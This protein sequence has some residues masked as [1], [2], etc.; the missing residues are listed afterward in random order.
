MDKLM[1]VSYEV[2][3]LSKEGWTLHARYPGDEQKEALTE[4]KA[5]EAR[6][7]AATKVIRS[8]YS[9]RGNEEVRKEIYS[10]RMTAAEATTRLPAP[11]K[12]EA[13]P[14]PVAVTPRPSK[15]PPDKREEKRESKREE[16]REGRREGKRGAK[17]RHDPAVYSP[18]SVVIHLLV[19]IA[20]AALMAGLITMTAGAIFGERLPFIGEIDLDRRRTLLSGLFM[21]TFLLM[22]VPWIVS[23]ARRVGEIDFGRDDGLPKAKTKP[24]I[25]APRDEPHQVGEGPALPMTTPDPETEPPREEYEEQEQLDPT[26]YPDA[27]PME[28]VEPEMAIRT[29]DATAP[30]DAVDAA[31]DDEGETTPESRQRAEVMRRSLMRFL[32]GLVTG[33][34]QTRPHLDAYERFGLGLL[35]TGAAGALA[36][37]TRVGP[38]GHGRLLREALGVLGSK[39]TAEVLLEEIAGQANEPRAQHMIE[40]GR[41]AVML[42]LRGGRDYMA[43]VL[44]ALEQWNRP[45]GATGT[46]V[47]AAL[48]AEAW[49]FSDSVETAAREAAQA[50]GGAVIG[51]ADGIVILFPGAARAVE[52]ALTLLPRLPAASRIGVDA[53]EASGEDEAVRSV[54]AARAACQSGM[55]GQ[56]LVTSVVRGLCSRLPAL[57]AEAPATAEGAPLFAVT[58][59]SGPA[60]EAVETT[61]EE[62]VET[63]D[64]APVE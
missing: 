5:A 60:A 62:P 13:P 57:F 55:P 40:A 29:R 18:G 64:T 19:I 54:G 3:V 34:Q 24:S 42:F 15:A 27:A 43:A 53:V 6:L 38:Q 30:G 22:A 2:Y 28:A 26:N 21:V 44:A 23:F 14:K 46:G 56:I 17:P 50:G 16:K 9:P 33:L 52:A 7:A 51:V 36:Q 49:P 10:S 35:I 58:P 39:A 4:A 37:G 48:V 20:S 12:K 41:A 45:A 32:G 25:K 8:E 61:T 47:V 1:V 11:P 59:V 31:G 63:V